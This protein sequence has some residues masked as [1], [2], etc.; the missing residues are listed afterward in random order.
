M[1][2]YKYKRENILTEQEVR[3]MIAESSQ[4]GGALMAFL[5][6]WGP[7]I[8]EALKLQTTDLSIKRGKL[9]ADLLTL[10]R[11]WRGPVPPRRLVGRPLTSDF[12]RLFQAYY[13]MLPPGKVWPFGRTKAWYLIKKVNPQAS[14]HLFRH[15]RASLMAEETGDPFKLWQFFG[16]TNFN[17]AI[18]YVHMRGEA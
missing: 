8:S 16:W 14:P 12:V 11:R 9:V 13:T 7:R 1:P 5:Y 4:D 15:T 17:T 18:S 10:K 6:E 3:L 2:L